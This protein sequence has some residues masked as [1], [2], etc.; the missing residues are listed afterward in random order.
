MHFERTEDGYACS[1][2]GN[3]PASITKEEF[4]HAIDKSAMG[5]ARGG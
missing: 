2:D 1:L 4:E 5:I 3:A